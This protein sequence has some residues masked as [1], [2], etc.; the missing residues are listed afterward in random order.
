VVL[1]YRGAAASPIA[2]VSV[3]T[4]NLGSGSGI[5]TPSVAGVS[6]S[7]A[8]AVV[9]L[10]LMSWQP[11]NTSVTW[12]TG[13]ASQAS[14]NDGFGYVSVGAK[15]AAQTSSSLPA[16]TVTLSPGEVVAPTLQVVILVHP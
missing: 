11:T 6:L 9:S 8:S 16:L 3:L 7:S 1:A 10:L 5:T 13:Y 14:A 15:L 4:N 12:P 2:G